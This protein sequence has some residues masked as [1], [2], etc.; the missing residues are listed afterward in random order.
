GGG[1]GTA[2]PHSRPAVRARFN[3]SLFGAAFG[4]AVLLQLMRAGVDA[5]MLWTGTDV[6]CG[7]GVL[8][9]QARPTPLYYAKKLC[10][11][12]VRTGDCVQFPTGAD[13]R[14]DLDAGV[15]RGDGG[16]HSALLVHLRQGKADYEAAELDC[17]MSACPR[18]LKI[19]AG[20]GGQVVEAPCEGR[21]TFEGYG[22]AVLTNA[23]PEVA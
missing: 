9:G 10:A 6:D 17:R 8:D 1:G 21:V 11:H 19:D 23:P 14:T 20:T 4:A 2:R 15:A 5:E 7:Y 13:G 16:R 3:Q 22:V 12:H 18:L